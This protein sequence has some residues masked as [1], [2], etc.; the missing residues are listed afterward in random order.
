MKALKIYNISLII[1]LIVFSF[2]FY[3]FFTTEETAINGEIRAGYETVE[4]LKVKDTVDSRLVVFLVS[5]TEMGIANYIK[6]PFG[7][8]YFC[9]E[10][11]IWDFSDEKLEINDVFK[12]KW[13]GYVIIATPEAVKIAN[14]AKSYG[15]YWDALRILSFFICIEGLLIIR[16][17]GKNRKRRE[18]KL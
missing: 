4:I 2:I 14:M 9:Q 18:A 12:G 1:V 5:E 11:Y 6:L 17:I 15:I 7:N 3:F 13:D 8:L 10:Q 16:I